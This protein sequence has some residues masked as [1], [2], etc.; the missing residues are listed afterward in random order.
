MLEAEYSNE[1]SAVRFRDTDNSVLGGYCSW[2]SKTSVMCQEYA[3]LLITKG[4][5]IRLQNAFQYSLAHERGHIGHSF[6]KI[7]WHYH[8]LCI[9][10]W[11]DEVLADIV[12]F[13]LIYPDW[14]NLSNETFQQALCSFQ[15]AIQYKINYIIVSKVG[16]SH[17]KKKYDD[18]YSEI[19]EHNNFKHP[20]WKNRYVYVSMLRTSSIDEIIQKVERDCKEWRSGQTIRK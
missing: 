1:I 6:L 8:N 20:S 15:D 9:A 10:H 11:V 13:Q 12:A 17:K 3:Y 19:N 7:L 16:K 2:F 5:D 4:D 18:I 14:E